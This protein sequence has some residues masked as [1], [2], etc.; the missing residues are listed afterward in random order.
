MKIS[1]TSAPKKTEVCYFATS[2]AVTV[3]ALTYAGAYNRS[4]LQ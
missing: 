3:L 2:L 1:R 4:I